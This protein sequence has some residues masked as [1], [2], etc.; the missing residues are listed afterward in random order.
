[1][2]PCPVEFMST[3]MW[4]LSRALGWAV[5]LIRQ[6]S[7]SSN[8]PFLSLLQ[9][10]SPFHDI[11]C[12]QRFFPFSLIKPFIQNWFALEYRSLINLKMFPMAPTP[13]THTYIH[14][15][16]FEYKQ[17]WSQTCKEQAKHLWR[18]RWISKRKKCLTSNSLSFW[19]PL[20]PYPTSGYPS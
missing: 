12:L 20:S 3:R 19:P 10:Y 15:R 17:W 18:L 9:L 1:M 4:Q 7:G 5:I 6:V 14:K 2:G 13:Y 11:W 8:I 16:E